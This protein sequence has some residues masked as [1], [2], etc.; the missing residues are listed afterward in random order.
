[1]TIQVVKWYCFRDRSGL[2]AGICV[3]I[4]KYININ[5]IM[6][7]KGH[8]TPL[9]GWDVQIPGH[10]RIFVMADIPYSVFL[11]RVNQSKN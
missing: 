9:A 1:M 3:G 5:Q 11:K 7:Q 10:L 6:N 2:T 8:K 4:M